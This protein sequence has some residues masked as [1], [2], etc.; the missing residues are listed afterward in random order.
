MDL[1]E[2][3]LIDMDTYR[4]KPCLTWIKTGSWYVR[5]FPMALYK[6]RAIHLTLHFSIT[7]RLENAAREFTTLE[8]Q[9]GVVQVSRFNHGYR[10]LR[11]KATLFPPILTL[12]HSIRNDYTRFFMVARLENCFTSIQLAPNYQEWHARLKIYTK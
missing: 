4:T 8:W 2:A 3:G 5:D 1:H 11:H 6:I 9:A 12:S 10:T 7:V